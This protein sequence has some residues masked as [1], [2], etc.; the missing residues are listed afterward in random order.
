MEQ[1]ISQPT[2]QIATSGRRFLNLAIDS[3]LYEIVMFLLVNPLVRLLF[4]NSF[5]SNY[6]TSYLFASIMLFLYYFAF[7]AVFQKT[8]AKFITGTKVV[9]V[10]GSKPE[11]GTIA[12]RSL[13][14]FVPFDA[15]SMYTGKEV[16]N[17]GTWWH[18][19]WVTTRVVKS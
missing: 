2:Y 11:I 14:R 4:G 10:D 5:F 3:I 18:D 6:W 13:I 1:P 8:P 12:L 15:I 19:R 17:K 9:T 16:A 7:E